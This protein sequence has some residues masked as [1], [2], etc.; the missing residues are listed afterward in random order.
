M[1]SVWWMSYALRSSWE[2]RTVLLMRN[3]WKWL[4]SFARKLNCLVFCA[5]CAKVRCPIVWMKFRR[6]WTEEKVQ[7]AR[8]RCFNFVCARARVC[9]C[10]WFFPI[11]S[12]LCG[13]S[14]TPKN[15]W[16]LEQKCYRALIRPFF[17]LNIKMWSSN[18]RLLHNTYNVLC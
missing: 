3:E 10:V 9:V 15:W 4:A 8:T 2:Q 7:E 5:V 11:Y 17:H 16:C 18:T 14:T 12:S 6:W 1:E 13:Q